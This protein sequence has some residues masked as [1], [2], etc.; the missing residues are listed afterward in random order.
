MQGCAGQMRLWVLSQLTGNEEEIS[1]KERPTK[2]TK[3]TEIHQYHT[4]ATGPPFANPELHSCGRH[5][6]TAGERTPGQRH[7]GM[8]AA[9]Y[10]Y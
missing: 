5:S 4:N 1:A 8:A 6:N 10:E 7:Q 2:C 9:L 3:K